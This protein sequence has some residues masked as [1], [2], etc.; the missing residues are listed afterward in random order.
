MKQPIFFVMTVSN[1]LSTEVAM[2]S[3]LVYICAKKGPWAVHLTLGLDW[4]GADIPGISIAVKHERV[5]R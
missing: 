3:I 5:P 4:G 1:L 2:I